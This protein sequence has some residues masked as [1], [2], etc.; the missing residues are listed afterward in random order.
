[1]SYFGD[2]IE[3]TLDPQQ[4]TGG[5]SGSIGAGAI[6]NDASHESARGA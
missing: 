2:A 5:W 1:M 4:P 3:F 6:F